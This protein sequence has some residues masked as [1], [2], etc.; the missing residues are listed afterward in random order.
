MRRGILFLM[1]VL[2]PLLAGGETV[3]RARYLMG[4]S[5]EIAV[6]ASQ[7]AGAEVEAAFAEAARIEAMLTTWNDSSELARLNAGDARI[8]AELRSLLITALDWSDRTDGAFNPRVKRLVELWK[9]REEGALP[10]A[11]EL[12]SAV[13]LARRHDLATLAGA[14]IEEGAFGKGYALD[15]MLAAL[16][17]EAL[18][19]FGGQVVVRGAH[20]VAVADPRDRERP[21]FAFTLR[22][23]SISTSSGSEKTF[24]I[25]GHDYSHI[26]DPRS[27]MALPPRGSVSVV[28]DEALTADIL[29]TAL[30]VM[31]EDDGLRWAD[32]N[33][34]AAI[35]I[36]PQNTIRLSHVARE[37]VRERELL[38]RKFRFQE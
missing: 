5:C 13:K 11:T 1:L 9:T 4:T 19:D 18:I 2:S 29:S 21:A 23:G 27:G 35:F 7:T 3:Q 28:A 22:D 12:E 24:R 30:Y 33:R 32:A 34:V 16:R 31:G 17:G 38:D 36:T 14:G 37:R 20:R 15:R 6:P 25:D 10:D 8:S 26:F